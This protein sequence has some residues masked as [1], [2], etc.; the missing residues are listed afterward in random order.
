[1]L[2]RLVFAVITLL[3]LGTAQARIEIPNSLPQELIVDYAGTL[4]AEQRTMLSEKLLGYY[5]ASS[6]VIV[7]ITIP[8]LEAVGQPSLQ[9]WNMKIA[10][11]WKPGNAHK[12]NGVIMTILGTKAPYKVRINPGYGLE[13]IL[14]DKF[15]KGLVEDVLKPVLNKPDSYYDGIVVAVDGL[16]SQNRERVRTRDKRAD[17]SEEN[18]RTVFARLSRRAGCSILGCRPALPSSDACGK[19]KLGRVHSIV[20]SFTHSFSAICIE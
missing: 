19:E 11:M 1:M 8:S 9:D 4:S 17:C 7:V 3:C 14:T 16:A 5:A 10:H 2:K 6:N 13:G 20:P 18:E 15:L 12:D